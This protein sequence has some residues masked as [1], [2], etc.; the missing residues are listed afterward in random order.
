MDQTQ[1]VGNIELVYHLELRHQLGKDLVT[2]NVNYIF[3]VPLGSWLLITER[4]NAEGFKLPG[5]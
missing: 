5:S 2:E 1:N 4:S 3:I